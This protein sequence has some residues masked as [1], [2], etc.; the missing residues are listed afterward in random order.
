[1]ENDFFALVKGF[2]LET[3][4]EDLLKQHTI[5]DNISTKSL[6]FPQLTSFPLFP[7][8]KV[9]KDLFPTNPHFKKKYIFSEIMWI[10]LLMWFRFIV[11]SPQQCRTTYSVSGRYLEGHV[12]STHALK[13]MG[14]CVVMCSNDQRCQSINFELNELICELNDADRQTYPWDYKNREGYAY[15]DYHAE[16]RVRFNAKLESFSLEYRAES[17][18]CFPVVLDCFPLIS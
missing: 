12:I 2:V 11:V 17:N 14:Q 8:S 5:S 18:S 1:M 6:L 15:K 4:W 7:T 9:G 3:E 10:L 16:V 13:N